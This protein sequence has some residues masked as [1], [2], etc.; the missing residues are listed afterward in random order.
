MRRDMGKRTFKRDKLGRFAKGGTV[1]TSKGP[2]K[3]SGSV[4]IKGFSAKDGGASLD[5]AVRRGTK[6]SKKKGGG[7]MPLE[8]Y[9]GPSMR[10][11]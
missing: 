4:S 7:S 3:G 1:S 8:G 9:D 11:K 6:S 2:S 10:G 5:Q